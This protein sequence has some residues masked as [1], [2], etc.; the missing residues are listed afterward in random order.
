MNPPFLFP[1]PVIWWEIMVLEHGNIII[2]CKLEMERHVICINLFKYRW[3]HVLEVLFVLQNDKEVDK[4][5]LDEYYFLG[6]T[7]NKI[8]NYCCI[9]IN[10][11]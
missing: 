10:T 5:T 4:L 2:L 11:A 1:R 8:S 3:K 7:S 9:K 6:V